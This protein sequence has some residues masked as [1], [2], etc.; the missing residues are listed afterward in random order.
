[1]YNV[2]KHYSTFTMLLN[3]NNDYDYIVII[4]DRHSN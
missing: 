3:I 2:K 1:M 4:K